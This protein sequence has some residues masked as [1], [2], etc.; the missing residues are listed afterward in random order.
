MN[1]LLGVLRL[2]S[3]STLAL[4]AATLVAEVPASLELATSRSGG[5]RSIH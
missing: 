2:P 1:Q 5:G 3:P 4:Y